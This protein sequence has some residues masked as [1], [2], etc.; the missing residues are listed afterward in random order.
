[1]A[2]NSYPELLETV[3]AVDWERVYELASQLARQFAPLDLLARACIQEYLNQ[4]AD[5]RP[6]T[7]R[8][9]DAALGVPSPD[10]LNSV[11]V[12]V[13]PIGRIPRGLHGTVRRRRRLRAGGRRADVLTAVRKI[14]NINRRA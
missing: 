7:Q 13:D 1:M 9:R 4:S 11:P 10:V 3:K 14:P 6:E 12:S 8:K 2:E 5:R